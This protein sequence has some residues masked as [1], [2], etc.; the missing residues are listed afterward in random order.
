MPGPMSSQGTKLYLSEAEVTRPITNV[1][2]AAPALVTITGAA[3]AV[4]D[5]VVPTGTGFAS[6]DGKAFEVEAV[7]AQV[8][9]LK[10]SD[11]SLET[12]AGNTGNLGL[13]GALTEICV[14]TFNRDS[15]AAATLDVTTLCD[16][17]RQ[18]L[19]G[20]KNNG[21]WTAAG[22]YDP[23]SAGQV[24]LRD[25]YDK[26]DKRLVD[27]VPPDKSHISFLSQINQLAETFGV[28]QPV[29]LNTGGL[30]LGNVSYTMPP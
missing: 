24:A 4:G 8:V 11:T 16:S 25:A 3:P 12:G 22:F 14:A 26:G 30:V 28:D 2:K 17:A 29:A 27:I 18:Q 7:A 19:T 5:M 9:T 20:M 10:S 23:T 15:P 21:T 6:I 1:S 13:Y